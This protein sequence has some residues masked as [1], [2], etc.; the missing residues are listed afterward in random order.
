MHLFKACPKCKGT[1]EWDVDEKMWVCL[2]CGIRVS[3]TQ[4]K[5]I[6]EEAYA[7]RQAKIESMSIQSN[8]LPVP[9]KPTEGLSRRG[10]NSPM[11]GYYEANKAQIIYE[12]KTHGEKV[13]ARR[14]HIGSAQW[15]T[16]KYRW[17]LPINPRKHS[18]T[19]SVL[20]DRR[21]LISSGIRGRE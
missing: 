15:T 7:E 18:R 11:N 14:W 3:Q 2:Q 8:L 12:A 21:P 1:L 13:T 9:P 10:L 6:V 19:Y 20:P 5:R 17:G 4:A 16:L